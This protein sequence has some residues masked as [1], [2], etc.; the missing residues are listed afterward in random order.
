MFGGAHCA[1]QAAMRKSRIADSFA[2]A[3]GVRLMRGKLL[4]SVAAAAASLSLPGC[5]PPG[6]A[7]DHLIGLW[8]GPHAALSLQGG[9]ADVQFD[10]ASGTIDDPLYPA[11]DGSFSAKGT[12]RTGAP[13]PIKVGEFFKS[14]PAVFSG[15]VTKGGAKNARRVMVLHVTLEDGTTLGPFTLAEGAP[16]QLTRCA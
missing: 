1:A 6:N 15:Q 7:S 5:A 9:L 10:C 12:Y 8:G 3:R 4:V 14:Q 16:P 11:A 13:G 2:P